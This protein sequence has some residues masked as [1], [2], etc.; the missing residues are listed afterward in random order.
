MRSRTAIGL[1]LF[2]LLVAIFPAEGK[3]PELIT[4]QHILIGFKKTVPNK[5]QDRSKAEAKALAYQLLKRAQDG[6]D[7]DALVEEYTNDNVPGIMIVTN[8]GAPRVTGGRT[9]SELVPKFG[10]VAFRLEVEEVGIAKFN[11]AI[12]PYGWH[13]IKRLE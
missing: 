6:E 8:K 4:V 7:F 5:P 12:S 9:R 2:C 10:D 13:V 3:E 11:T 1:V